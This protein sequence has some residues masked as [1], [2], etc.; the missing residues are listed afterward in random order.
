MSLFNLSFQNVIL[1]DLNCRPW[2]FFSKLISLKYF[3]CNAIFIFLFLAKHNRVRKGSKFIAPMDFRKNSILNS[4]LFILICSNIFS[5]C[6]CKVN[7]TSVQGGELTHVRVKPRIVS[8]I[9]HNSEM[10]AKLIYTI[11]NEQN[12]TV[13]GEADMYTRKYTLQDWKDEQ[14]S[15]HLAFLA[16]SDVVSRCSKKEFDGINFLLGRILKR[17]YDMVIIYRGYKNCCDTGSTIRCSNLKKTFDSQSDFNINFDRE[18]GRLLLLKNR[19]Q[20][21]AYSYQYICRSRSLS[22]SSSSRGKGGNAMSKIG[23]A[24]SEGRVTRKCYDYDSDANPGPLMGGTLRRITVIFTS[25]V[26]ALF[27]LF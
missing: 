13:K 20:D 6:V 22:S 26:I 12:K 5:A 9:I 10:F 16:M 11:W 3:L 18:V 17:W 24:L 15:T 7:E 19:V 23:R 4:I 2:T 14:S 27:Y 21:D 8:F 1:K 25:F